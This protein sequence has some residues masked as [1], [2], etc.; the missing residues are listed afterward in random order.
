[1]MMTLGIMNDLL[2]RA[3][4]LP[5][6]D[7]G[8]RTGL[9]GYIDYIRMEEI[10]HPAMWGIDRFGRKFIVMKLLIDGKI[11]LQTFF[12]RYACFPKWQ[13][14]G[15]WSPN[16]LLFSSTV[17]IG[18]PQI[19]LIMSLIKGKSVTITQEHDAWYEYI[20]K[21]VVLFDEQ[22][23]NAAIKIQKQWRRCRWNPK[24]EMCSRVQL[25]NLEDVY[26]Q[27]GKVL[28]S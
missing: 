5:V 11:I 13:G 2:T 19:N 20:G 10:T 1:M 23:W 24:Y 17:T 27:N 16:E 18:K 28:Q 15:N 8:K 22:K 4:T 3:E 9:T 12:Q 25:H 26:T 7:T 21:T 14:C 6:F